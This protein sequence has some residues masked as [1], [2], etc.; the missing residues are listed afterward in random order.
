MVFWEIKLSCEGIQQAQCFAFYA[1]VG[2]LLLPL[3]F[4]IVV[5]AQLG[6]GEEGTRV[7]LASVR[8]NQTILHTNFKPQINPPTITTFSHTSSNL[9]LKILKKHPKIITYHPFQYKPHINTY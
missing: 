7:R 6:E 8:G 4:E 9:L 2:A 3:D 5:R 1:P